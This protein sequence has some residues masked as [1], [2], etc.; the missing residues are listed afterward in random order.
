MVDVILV[1]ALESPTS[2]AGLESAADLTKLLKLKI[3]YSWF[4]TW[5]IVD[6]CSTVTTSLHVWEHIIKNKPPSGPS[7]FLGTSGDGELKKFVT[8]ILSERCTKA[9][10]KSMFSQIKSVPDFIGILIYTDK[11]DYVRRKPMLFAERSHRVHMR[12]STRWDRFLIKLKYYQRIAPCG[13]N[14]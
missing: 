6:R 11:I 7:I 13:E 1:F 12:R 9:I 8:S 3:K 4:F 14:C 5:K 2:S 10:K